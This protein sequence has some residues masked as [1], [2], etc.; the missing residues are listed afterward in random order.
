M[1]TRKSRA[2]KKTPFEVVFGQ[3][4]NTLEKVPIQTSDGIIQEEDVPNFLQEIDF[5]IEDDSSATEKGN[6]QREVQEI[7]PPIPKPRPKPVSRPVPA[8]RPKPIPKI[9]PTP[10]PRPKPNISQNIISTTGRSEANSPSIDSSGP[11]PTSRTPTVNK[12]IS[13]VCAQ[14]GS[15]VDNDLPEISFVNKSKVSRKRNTSPEVMSAEEKQRK[16]ENLLDGIK[17]FN[18]IK[19]KKMKATVDIQA[20]SSTVVIGENESDEELP[21]TPPPKRVKFVPSITK[22]DIN[23]DELKSYLMENMKELLSLPFNE[24]T[25]DNDVEAQH[26]LLVYTTEAK[27]VQTIFC[28]H[29]PSLNSFNRTITDKLLYLSAETIRSYLQFKTNGKT[30]KRF[31][32]SPKRT[33]IRNEVRQNINKNAVKMKEQFAKKKKV[34]VQ[35]FQIGDNVAVK[36]PKN[37]RSKVAMQ[38]I[39]AV[40]VKLKN[41]TP[42]MYKL[43]CQNGTLSGYFSTSELI[44]FPGVVRINNEDKEISLREAAKLHSITKEVTI[45]CKCKKLCQNKSCPCKKNDRKCYSRCHLGNS[46]KNMSTTRDHLPSFGGSISLNGI[47]VHFSNTC[48]VD[49]WLAIFSMIIQFRQPLYQCMLLYAAENNKGFSILMKLILERE[50]NKAKVELTKMC[51]IPFVQRCYDFFGDEMSRFAKF[52]TFFLQ[53]EMTSSCSS[54]YCQSKEMKQTLCAIPAISSNNG[55]SMSSFRQTVIGW[56]SGSFEASCLRPLQ[57]PLPAEEFIHFDKN[58]LTYV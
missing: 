28:K 10:A 51:K 23:M 8:P 34:I 19:I 14:N 16:F 36:V 24:N 17:Q 6:M 4:P 35:E 15:L 42:P 44:S 52:L 48:P 25:L 45:F 3:L 47:Q 32:T 9:R 37:D 33:R 5:S 11:R 20:L 53:Y 21:A 18:K 40:V 55:S 13:S 57:D 22:T 31:E 43:A 56:M 7:N 1:D 39:P 29:Q 50:F 27:V 58:T 38:R 30:L 41:T 49:N 46:C 2:T 54:E 26:Y 12:D